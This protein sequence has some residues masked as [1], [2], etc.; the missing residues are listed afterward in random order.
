MARVGET[1]TTDA[2]DGDSLICFL[3]DK[4]KKERENNM[5][6]AVSAVRAVNPY[7][8]CDLTVGKSLPHPET[9]GLHR[10]RGE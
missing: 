5:Q 7:A 3:R 10:V 6:V 8:S 9:P 1:D 2:A 4:R